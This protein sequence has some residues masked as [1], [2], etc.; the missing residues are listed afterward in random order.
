MKV[1]FIHTHYI[2]RGGEDSVVAN[3]I[4]LL[5]SHGITAEVLIFNNESRKPHLD[6]LQLPFNFR[7][8]RLTKRKIRA[9]KPD[10]VHIHNLHFAGSAS[11]IYAVKH[12]KLPIVSTLHDYRLLCPTGNLFYNEKLF[13]D[14]INQRF[15][16]EA[17]KQGM[18]MNSYSSSLWL[19][20]SMLLHHLLGTWNKVDRFIVYSEFAKNIFEQSKL[21]SIADRMVIKPNFSFTYPDG[22][23]E[24]DESYYLYVGTLTYDKGIPAMLEAFA[25]NGIFL[26]VVGEGPLV[27]LIKGYGQHYPNIRYMGRKP[28]EDVFNMMEHASALI[29]P[30]LWFEPFGMV[31]AEAFSK[32]T[33]VIAS[34]LGNIKNMVDD[35]YNGLRFETNNDKDLR[36]KVEYYEALPDEEK[37][38]YRENARKTYQKK[39]SPALHAD[40][41]ISI[42]NSVL[43]T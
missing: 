43:K 28:K 3:Q 4:E 35:G 2:F 15:P 41:L 16:V 5:R 25:D 33:P 1:L 14:S 20:F 19:S 11:V 18:F 27:P 37:A 40:K 7:S 24:K 9:F 17:I 38:I 10:V 21:K 8:Y 31:I 36:A 29:F 22:Q 13:M 26:K 42:Y 32:G 12:F 30:T 34:D 39:Y 23:I 6:Q